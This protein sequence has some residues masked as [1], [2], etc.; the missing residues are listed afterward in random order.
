VQRLSPVGGHALREH[1]VPPHVAPQQLAY[2]ADREHVGIDHD[3]APLVTHDARDVE[4]E[5][6]KGL[7]IVLDPFHFPTL[8]EV[9]LAV[10]SGDV[11]IVLGPQDAHVEGVGLARACRQRVLRDQRAKTLL[12]IGVDEDG[13]THADGGPPRGCPSCTPCC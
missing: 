2:V 10:A 9:R 13:V 4:A 12:P 7:Q 6:R 3:R 11:R 8:A 5:R 1:R